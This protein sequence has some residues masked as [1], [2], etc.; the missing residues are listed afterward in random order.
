MALL[1]GWT[2]SGANRYAI[3]VRADQGLNVSGTVTLEWRNES[4]NSSAEI[5]LVCS[6]RMKRATI[7]G[8]AVRIDKE[9][10]IL[11]APVA[12]GGTASVRIE[13][14]EGAKARYGYR[15]LTGPWHPKA[16]TF[17]NGRYNPNQ[18]Q[19]DDYDVTLTA[20]PA[21]IVASAGELVEQ[22]QAAEGRRRWHWRLPHATS[23]GLA[24]ST[25]FVET[26]RNSQ[27]VEIRLYQLR[28]D[29]RF[30]PVMADYAA[31]AIAYYR[32]LFQ[33][34]PH[35]AV[36]MLPG[37]FSSGG[38]YAPASGITIFHKNTG[39]YH[40]RW[41]VAH[42]VAHQYWGFDTVIDDGDFCHWPGLGLGL[43]SDQ[44][45][46]AER[47]RGRYGS[48]RYRDA[49][50]RGFDTTIRRPVAQ[51][52]KLEFDWNNIISHEK[53]YAVVRMLEELMGSE[54]FL[55]FVNTLLEQYR[56]Q[57]LSF[58]AFQATAEKIAG[59][60]LDWFF[61]D[62]VDTNGVASYAIEGVHTSESGVQVQ[63]RRTGTARFPIE[64][65]LTAEDGSQNTRRIAVEQEVQ[66]LDFAGAG[67]P[68]RIELE[69]RGRCP[70]LKQGKELWEG[71]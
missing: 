33:F 10:L 15:M 67:R 35:P 65:R 48:G 3:E 46:M 9:R 26:R 1:A 60:K 37:A 52:R 59:Q 70:L 68:K 36:V 69:P 63:V 50:A 61:H 21:L 54:R 49:V 64:V 11:P 30:D 13:F 23:F 47:E 38:G 16:L 18:Q 53:S 12:P 17:R 31:D 29:S 4:G 25:D 43:Y 40:V 6:G 45:Y 57:Y 8:A 66:T 22:S 58:D 5:P 14:E 19:A 56:Y 62:W 44:R 51:M 55:Q 28:G 71:Q 42:E 34:Y 2:A 39:D 7:G 32:R 20:P 24:A 41:I 27:G